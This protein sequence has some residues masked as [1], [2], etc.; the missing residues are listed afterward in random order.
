MLKKILKEKSLKAEAIFGL[1]PANSIGDNIEV[2]DVKKTK[3]LAKFLTLRQQ[4][5]LIIGE[6]SHSPPEPFG[7][8]PNYTAHEEE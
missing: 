3:T 6:S 5:R 1:F 7:I 4:F 2:Y 8:L